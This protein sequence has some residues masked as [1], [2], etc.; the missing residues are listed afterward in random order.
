VRWEKL[1]Q[2]FVPSGEDWWARSHASTPTVT[3]SADGTMRVYYSSRDD[4][5]RSHVG[6]VDLDPQD[7]F[8]IANIDHQPALSPGEPGLFDDSGVSVGSVVQRVGVECLYYMGW[9]LKVTVPW[10]NSI[11]MAARSSPDESF[12]RRGRVPVLDRSEEDPFSMSY[13]WVTTT[14]SG[15]TMW[16]GTNIAWGRTTDTMQHVI[17]RATSADGLVWDRDASPCV[18]FVHEGE[19]AISRPCVRSS[20]GGLEMFYSYRSHV[21]PTTYRL[22]WA[23]SADGLTWTRED[24]AIGLAPSDAGW[25]ADMVC[26]P[27]VFDWAGETW[28]F[29]NGNGYGRTGFGLARRVVDPA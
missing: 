23:F 3:W 14:D 1:G 19:Y 22:G 25:D 8:R 5:G 21:A 27:C 10:A 2:V 18:G 15:L 17:R 6:A 24:D 16:Y 20:P 7:H 9:N 11:G 4:A 28:M 29:Y 12:A 26:Y 13:P